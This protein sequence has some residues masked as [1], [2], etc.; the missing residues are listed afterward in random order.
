MVVSAV[1]VVTDVLVSP[2][3]VVTECCEDV[4]FKS[5]WEIFRATVLFFLPQS[6]PLFVRSDDVKVEIEALELL[7]DPE[8][9]EVC[10]QEGEPAGFSR[11]PAQN[12]KLTTQWQAQIAGWS[13]NE[14]GSRSK[15]GG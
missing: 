11:C 9:S 5:D 13:T 8:D 3:S 10:L 7:M 14:R 6:V 4:S 15:R 2:S 12:R 1:R